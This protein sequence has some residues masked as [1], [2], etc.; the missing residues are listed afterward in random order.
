MTTTPDPTTGSSRR[1]LWWAAIGIVVVIAV[2]LAIVLTTRSGDDKEAPGASPAASPTASAAPGASAGTP[3]STS[4]AVPDPA[5][6]STTAP[7]DGSVPVLPSVEVSLASID[8]IDATAESPGEVSG[9]ALRVTVLVDNQSAAAIDLSAA[10]AN[11]YFGADATPA[12]ILDG[13]GA[14]PFPASVEAG[15]QATGVFVF[16]VPADQRDQV[17]VEVGYSAAAPVAIFS[18]PAPA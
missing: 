1:Y 8:A 17:R 16:S 15:Q 3:S 2:V 5:P 10:I 11:L 6:S 4:S 9:P 12:S 14:Q 18:G 13:S 7:L